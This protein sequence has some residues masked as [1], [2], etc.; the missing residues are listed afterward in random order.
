[1]C[2]LCKVANMIF[3]TH[4][5]YLDHQFDD[6]R[7]SLLADLYNGG[8]KYVTEVCADINDCDDIINLTKQYKFIYGSVG[9]HP[10]NVEILTD[11]DMDK[12]ASLCSNEKIVAIGEIGLDYYFEENPPHNVQKYWFEKQIEVAK[13]ANMPLIIHSR[14]A[15]KDTM[16]ILK[17]ANASSVGG[18]IHCYSYSPEMAKE[19][20]NMGFYI[21]VGGVVTF[22]NAKKLKEV[23]ET[24]PL[25]RIV[26]ETDC[27]YMAPT[28]HRG[29]RNSS[30][31]IPH[32]VD[33]ISAIKGI[34]PT[35][36]IDAT[37]DNALKMYRL[38]GLKG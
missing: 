24:I 14:D 1:M 10:E 7:H 25:D 3:D 29:K 17:A 22:K 6:D 27:P 28:P 31:Y 15:A 26:L 37:M 11:E 35:E 16:D 8:I 19:F 34:S 21:G 9:V 5:H 20:I 32:I 2:V 13:K 23:V 33:E 36:I 38:T 18:V 4:A 30:L 12:L